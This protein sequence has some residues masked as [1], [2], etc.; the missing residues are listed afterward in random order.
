[1][2]HGLIQVS[3]APGGVPGRHGPRGQEKIPMTEKWHNV[4]GMT[5]VR[6]A[7]IEDG[8]ADAAS[9]RSDMAASHS[10]VKLVIDPGSEVQPLGDV[11]AV[12]LHVQDGALRV[13]ISE[14][15]AS[16]NVASGDAIRS[17]DADIVYC[18]QGRRTMQLGES[19]VLRSGNTFAIR[20]GVMHMAVDG[21]APA[22]LQVSVV[23]KESRDTD[24][25]ADGGQVTLMAC[26]LCPFM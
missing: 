6:V 4:P 16:V 20:D 26:W 19:A 13:S 12:N 11:H 15:D 21:D 3:G 8:D 2:E 1:L 24:D 23:K 5:G 18:E 14:G 7:R 9:N 17:G 22:E 25:E 10:M